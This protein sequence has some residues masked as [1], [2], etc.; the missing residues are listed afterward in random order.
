MFTKYMKNI[1]FVCILAVVLLT[2]GCSSN[3]KTSDSGSIND[4]VSDLIEIAESKDGIITITDVRK[5]A[6]NISNNFSKDQIDDIIFI[7][8]DYYNGELG[9][10]DYYQNVCES[11]S[12]NDVKDIYNA[13]SNSGQTDTKKISVNDNDDD[14]SK[15]ETETGSVSLSLIVFRVIGAVLLIAII[16]VLVV[17]I[18]R[19]K[20]NSNNKNIKKKNTNKSNDDDSDSDNDYDYE[21][22]NNNSDDEDDEDSDDYD[23]GI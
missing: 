4:A 16:V 18:V 3:K 1:F 22:D 12:G 19:K 8:N 15:D 13:V 10:L 5:K 14:N 20:G 2:T 6:K 23:F 17:L 9:G 7:I 21:N 11:L